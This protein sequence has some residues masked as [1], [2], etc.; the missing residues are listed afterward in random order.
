MRG[1]M[2]IYVKIL[3]G[4]TITLEVEPSDT[5]ENVKSKI[6]HQEGTPPHQ[7][8]LHFV[9]KQ[10]ENG[11]TLSDYNIQKESTLHLELHVRESPIRVFNVNLLTSESIQEDEIAINVKK[12]L[13]FLL[14]ILADKQ[15]LFYYCYMCL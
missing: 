7:Q 5:I 14:G 3:T 1:V 2:Q 15:N 10:L 8:R 6:Q 4:K 12:M 13:E 9:G 11:R